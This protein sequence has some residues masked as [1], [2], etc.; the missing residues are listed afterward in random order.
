MTSTISPK[1]SRAA[2]GTLAAGALAF[3]SATPALADD[4]RDRDRGGIGA[5]EIIAGA[6]V[7][8]G[9]AALAGAFDGD[10]DRWDRRDRRGWRGD[11][12]RGGGARGAVERC[13]RAAE[14][15]ARRFGGWRFADVTEIRDVDRTRFG[16][17]V[18]G[19]MVVE[20]SPRFRGRNF[21]R[22][23]FTC[24]LDGRGAPR[25]DFDG[26]RGLR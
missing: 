11:G 10:R 15:Q 13:V 7:I 19:R 22:G 25:I 16:F 4:H 2:L 14:N 5:G 1:F 26:I 24:R 18:Q 17:R 6:V 23:R 3:A 21:D 20:G 9:I 12:F 8:G